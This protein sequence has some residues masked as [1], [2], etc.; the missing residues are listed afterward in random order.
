MSLG[1]ASQDKFAIEEELL[2]LRERNQRVE[3][4]KAWETS[5]SRRL[6][7]TGTT[8]LAAWLWLL[9]LGT[10]YAARQAVIPSAAYLLSTLSLPVLRRRW[11]QHR[12]GK[13]S[14]PLQ[15]KRDGE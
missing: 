10:L 8:Y 15:P 4:D 7:V 5:W 12:Q 14:G 9:D 1:K 2:A 6:I 11:I 13:D 3:L